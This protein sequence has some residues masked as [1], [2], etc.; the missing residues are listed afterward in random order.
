MLNSFVLCCNF[1]A[2]KCVCTAV[3]RSPG[4]GGGRH[5][6]TAPKGMVGDRLPWGG[7]GQGG[8]V[9]IYIYIYIYVCMA[10]VWQ[11]IYWRAST[12]GGLW[13]ESSDPPRV[14]DSKQHALEVN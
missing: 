3:M 9:C 2:C 8:G 14:G 11:S 5:L 7:E 1:C 10:Y 6:V 4:G 12:P 13:E